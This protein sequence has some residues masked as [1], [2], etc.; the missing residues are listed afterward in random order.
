MRA[1][2]I[3]VGLLLLFQCPADAWRPASPKHQVG[4]KSLDAKAIN[5]ARWDSSFASRKSISPAVIRAEIL[6]ARMNF[7]PGEISGRPG[8]NLNKAIAAFAEGQEATTNTLDQDLWDKLV[9]TSD[10]PV[11]VD[12]KISET[13]IRGPFLKKLPKKM[14]KMK[15][16]EHLSYTSPK[17]KSLLK[18]FI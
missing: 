7:S 8:E 13:D 15:D 17:E 3:S 5:V 6:L 1:L 12:Y 2:L 11:V 16:L 18:N 9:S 10:D 4:A 14:E